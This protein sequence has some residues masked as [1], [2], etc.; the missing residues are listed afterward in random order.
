MN[1]IFKANSSFHVNQR[2]MEKVQFFASSDKIF[3]LGGRLIA[4]L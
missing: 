3:I 1:K 2:T 4:R